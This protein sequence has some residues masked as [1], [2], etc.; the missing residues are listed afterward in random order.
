[1]F[2]LRSDRWKNRI[3]VS[4]GTCRLRLLR[5]RRG[6]LFIRALTPQSKRADMTSKTVVSA[7]V[8]CRPDSHQLRQNLER[9]DVLS[10]SAGRAETKTNTHDRKAECEV[11]QSCSICG[12]RRSNI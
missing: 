7:S 3:I 11:L 6:G 9:E 1:M 8:S 12:L 10:G 4:D 2:S 5:P